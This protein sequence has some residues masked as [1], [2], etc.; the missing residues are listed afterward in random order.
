V[1]GAPSGARGG[2]AGAMDGPKEGP[3]TCRIPQPEGAVTTDLRAGRARSAVRSGDNSGQREGRPRRGGA[4]DPAKRSGRADRLGRG[5]RARFRGAKRA[6]SRS[7]RFPARVACDSDPGSG[8]WPCR[9]MGST[10]EPSGRGGLSP[11]SRRPER[12]RGRGARGSGVGPAWDEC[13][14]GK[15]ERFRGCAGVRGGQAVSE[16]DMCG[17]A[18]TGDDRP[19]CSECENLGRRERPR[20]WRWSDWWGLLRTHRRSA[21]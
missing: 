3:A 20:F 1:R 10:C 15:L 9:P 2:S 19:S 6:T 13:Q 12:E 21:A 17:Q 5:R 11:L 8:S 14:L 16:G 4:P 18:W 7:T